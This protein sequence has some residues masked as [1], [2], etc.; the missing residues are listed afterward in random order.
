MKY[1]PQCGT[2]L[3]ENMKFCPECGQRLV[4]EEREPAQEKPKDV[5]T[6]TV[7]IEQAD[8]TYYL[9]KKGVRVTATRLI[10]PKT[11]GSITYAMANITSISTKTVHPTLILGIILGVVGLIMLAVFNVWA[12]ILALVGVVLLIIGIILA[13][14]REYRLKVTSAAG[15]EE[16]L[17]SRDRK[18]I[19]QIAVAV[20]EALIK[21]G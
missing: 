13:V 12:S 10:I 1:C 17:R 20:N 15:E 2:K 9:D 8:P 3:E 21:R 7:T 5:R 4:T 18:Y 16:P 19:N 6:G 11:H 14:M